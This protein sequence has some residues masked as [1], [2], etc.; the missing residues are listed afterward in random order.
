MKLRHITGWGLQRYPSN[1]PTRIVVYAD[2]QAAPVYVSEI[3]E[4]P[5]AEFRG[6][7]FS[8]LGKTGSADRLAVRVFQQT[9]SK[10]NLIHETELVLE[11]ALSWVVDNDFGQVNGPIVV[12]TVRQ[13]WMWVPPP[14]ARKSKRGKK[15]PHQQSDSSLE[16]VRP[17]TTLSYD[18]LVK[19][20]TLQMCLQDSWASESQLV[21]D[22][23]ERLPQSSVQAR[24]RRDELQRKLKIT[25]AYT[26]H[27]TLATE[28]VRA[29]AARILESSRRVAGHLQKW[30]D[31]WPAHM[32]QPNQEPQLQ[33][34]EAMTRE[35]RRLIQGLMEIFPIEPIEKSF[36][37]TICG[38]PMPSVFS[39]NHYDPIQV[40]AVLGLIA[41]LV[42]LL[43]RYLDV[44]LPYPIR[45]YGSQSYIIDNV[46]KL[47]GSRTF[48]LWTKGALLYR[49]EYGLYLLHKNIE[50]LMNSQNLAVADL[51]Q[52]L[53]NLK[54][55]MLVCS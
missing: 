35:R 22:I 45:P 24:A 48:P 30:H 39:I 21:T 1:K 41:Q 23:A 17:V 34:E 18:K 46:S 25:Q 20:H 44:A 51:K 53:A 42:V 49:V 28:R 12:F 50:Q 29:E 11:N 26:T 15:Q 4:V 40:G 52:T 43:S 32:P 14:S 36:H 6:V 5:D 37:F 13:H 33:A 19:L 3:L 38:L 10:W 2:C 47:Q 9:E 27:T 31:R 7:D 8:R 54:N 16:A 55:L